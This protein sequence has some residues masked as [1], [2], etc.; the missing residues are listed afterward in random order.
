MTAAGAAPEGRFASSGTAVEHRAGPA[1]GSSSRTLPGHSMTALT[2]PAGCRDRIGGA[3]ARPLRARRRDRKIR[4]LGHLAL[5]T[6]WKTP[7]LSTGGRS[8]KTPTLTGLKA[9]AVLAALAAMP[10]V[11]FAPTAGIALRSAARTAAAFK[12][13]KSLVHLRR[14]PTCGQSRRRHDRVS[15]AKW[16]RP[17][18][19]LG[20]WSRTQGAG[21]GPPDGIATSRWPRER[22]HGVAGQCP[23]R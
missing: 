19:F 13:V 15:R 12:P 9:A 16:P 3:D 22:R 14:P 8:T 2:R 7:A 1:H 17:A 5:D 18:E 20:A 10:A 23:R 21:I 11:A 4:V 6:R